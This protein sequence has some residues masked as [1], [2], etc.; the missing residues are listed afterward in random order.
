MILVNFTVQRYRGSRTVISISNERFTDFLIDFA[1][2]L[3]QIFKIA[4][5]YDKEKLYKKI[6][7]FIATVIL[8]L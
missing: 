5:A 2:S 4:A 1:L 6:D 7:F 8:L 3:T